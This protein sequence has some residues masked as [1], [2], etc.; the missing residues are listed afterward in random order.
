MPKRTRS[1]SLAIVA[2]AAGTL[3]ARTLAAGA[4]A[5][6]ASATAATVPDDTVTVTV[7]DAGDPA[8]QVDLQTLPSVGDAATVSIRSVSGGEMVIGDGEGLDMSAI[9]GTVES[10][11]VTDVTGPGFVADGELVEFEATSA[12][13]EE[14]D[15]FEHPVTELL[16]V[17]LQFT[18]VSPFEVASIELADGSDID[19][20]ASVLRTL[21]A[22]EM[23]TTVVVPD[24]P[25]GEGATWTAAPPLTYEGATLPLVVDY[26][27]VSITD[28]QYE[29][30]FSADLTEDEVL[31]L[32]G[33][34]QRDDI[35]S[36][37][38]SFE[39]SGT[40]SGNV[41]QAL[42]TT[43]AVQVDMVLD[44]DYVD[45]DQDGSATMTLAIERVSTP[46]RR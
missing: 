38:G 32:M 15:E 18:F 33:P 40:L 4:T 9:V 17:P 6:A 29:I 43:V 34:E 23:L 37:D 42:D 46:A 45:P 39:Y 26:E 8:A 3:A 7:T 5:A 21:E 12:I 44:V 13:S 22:I 30:A 24:N 10:V 35:V 16:G 14:R 31:D 20:S 41:N 19:D 2:L 27:L 25:I 28:G 1:L 36:V 11:E